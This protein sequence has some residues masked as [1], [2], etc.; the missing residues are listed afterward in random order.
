MDILIICNY[1][2]GLL[3]FRGLLIKRMIKLGYSVSAII[4]N[5]DNKAEVKSEEGLKNLGCN[6]IKIPMERRGMNPLIDLQLMYSYYK[7][8]KKL[9]PTLVI[10][11]TIKPNIYAC[12]ICR[13]LKVPYVA[14]IT[15]LGTAFQKNNWIKRLVVNM[16]KLSLKCAK[17]VFFE[18]VE[19][20]EIIVG[21]GIV[22][23]IQTQVLPG[24]GV[25]LDKF[26]YQPYPEDGEI[27][28]F[29]FMGRV[30]REKGIDELFIA[31]KKLISEGLNCSLD[32]CGTFEEDYK[33]KI[34][35]Y[36]YSGWLHYHGV[37]NDV[38]PFLGDCHCFVL[39]SWHEGMANTNLEAAASGRPVITSN[40]HGCLESIENGVSGY[41][42]EHKN[43][44]DLYEKMKLFIG[45]SIKKRKDMGIEG[46]KRMERIF[47]KTKVVDITIEKMG[48]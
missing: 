5:A 4:P 13:Y 36:E 43:S 19:N 18:N 41:L 35:E 45:L 9:N 33:S 11:Y 22:P 1:A 8:I 46:R 38:R 23:R 39:P 28:R 6:I 30:M 7:N 15:G 29:L 27:V 24:A 40:I 31:M 12:M 42:I 37:Q 44:T 3:N 32:I 2:S 34:K 21:F 26:S 25:D 14:N 48:L 16:Y 17:I 10:T 47:D 20:R